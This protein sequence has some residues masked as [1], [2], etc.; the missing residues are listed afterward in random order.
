MKLH[1]ALAR[2]TR[3]RIISADYWILLSTNFVSCLI[4]VSSIGISRV[5]ADEAAAASAAARRPI[6]RFEARC[7]DGSVLR[8]TLLES[9]I[10]LKTDYGMVMIPV[11][12]IGRI[13]FATRISPEVAQ[14]IKMAIERLGDPD[15]KARETAMSELLELERAAY[16]ALLEAVKSDDPEVMLRADRLL[17]EIRRLAPEEELRVEHSDVVHAGKSQI[18][19]TIDITSLKVDTAAFGQQQL[20]LLD[21][22]QLVAESEIDRD[23]AD[24][25]ADPGNL[26]TYQNQIGKTLYFRVTGP[27]AGMQHGIVWGSDIYTLDSTLALAAVH[28]GVVKPGQSKVI[29]VTIVGP[30]DSFGSSARNGVMS[31]NWGTFP[32]AFKFKA[33]KK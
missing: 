15:F 1:D 29:G 24:G 5:V 2:L 21:L 18:A 14:R 12:D 7:S 16:P 31:N 11:G 10:P 23:P 25:I 4:V 28:A 3:R 30:Q 22:R 13:D 19:G 17:E 20:K 8:L 6:A 9:K 33:A 26:F 32:A 27:P